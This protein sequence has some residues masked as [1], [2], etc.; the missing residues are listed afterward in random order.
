MKAMKALVFAKSE[1]VVDKYA[2]LQLL[3]TFQQHPHFTRYFDA[4]W[5]RRREWV[6]SHRLG[7]FTRGN[8]T[9]NYDEVVFCIFKYIICQRTKAF[10]LIQLFQFITV[11]L[12]QYYELRLLHIGHSRFDRALSVRFYGWDGEK[13]HSIAI[14]EL[15]GTLGLYSVAGVSNPQQNRNP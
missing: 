15:G 3:D 7:L 10:N 12:E 2:D 14:T 9:N 4:I 6:T 5:Q 11:N 8:N 1:D 13:V